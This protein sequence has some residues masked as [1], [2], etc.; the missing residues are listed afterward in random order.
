MF[1]YFRAFFEILFEV[2]SL[3]ACYSNDR[4]YESLKRLKIS[5]PGQLSNIWFL[6][7]VSGKYILQITF[8]VNFRLANLPK[9]ERKVRTKYQNFKQI[10][11]LLIL[12]TMLIKLLVILFIIILFAVYMHK[13]H[14]WEK[15]VIAGFSNQSY[16][17]NKLMKWPDFVC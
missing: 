9:L 15:S 14:I 16:L 11:H 4:G 2:N 8:S 12:F 17:H 6:N 7:E 13:S 1:V 3:C 10:L 5:L